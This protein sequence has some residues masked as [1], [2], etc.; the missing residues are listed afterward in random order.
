MRQDQAIQLYHAAVDLT[1][2][3]EQGTQ[4]GANV[5]A[6]LAAVVAAP[7]TKAAA[8]IIAWWRADWS[9]VGET[10]S[11]FLATFAGWLLKSWSPK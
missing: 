10:R 5:G 3:E 6:E 7:D 9:T 1:T 2:G 4:W 11:A 8:V